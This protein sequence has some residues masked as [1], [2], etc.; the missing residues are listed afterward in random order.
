M[1]ISVFRL[2][3]IVSALLIS[4]C[5]AVWAQVASSTLAGSVADQQGKR[6]PQARVRITQTTT[7]LQRE[8]E[9]TSQ[10]NYELVDLPAGTFSVQISKDGFS[11]FEPSAWNRSWDKPG[12]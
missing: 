3:A 5:G 4:L 9:T 11:T 6:I 12:R 10:G 1:K 2:F 8:A 7:G